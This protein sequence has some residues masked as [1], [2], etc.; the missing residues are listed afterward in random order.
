VRDEVRPLPGAR[1]GLVGI[2][3][4]D[5]HGDHLVLLGEP[6][7]AITGDPVIAAQTVV[8]DLLTVGLDEPVGASRTS[9][10]TGPPLNPALVEIVERRRLWPGADQPG[11]R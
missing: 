1:T 2:R 8:D 5:K 9:S 11:W 4:L 10:V 6:L 7:R 3:A